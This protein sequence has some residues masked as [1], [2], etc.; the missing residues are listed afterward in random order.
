MSQ[1]NVEVA[2]AFQVAFNQRDRAAITRLT[3]ADF[4]FIPML[5]TLEGR[6]YRGHAELLGWIDSL[7][8]D[9]E[10]FELCPEEYHDLG[11][12]VL[13]LGHWRAR[14]RTSGIEFEGQPGAWLVSVREGRLSRSETFTDRDA[15]LEAASRSGD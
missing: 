14:G 2:R 9:W 13:C 7:D 3:H 1:E 10:T 6:V 15:A 4:E 11:G 12:S 5:A 8:E